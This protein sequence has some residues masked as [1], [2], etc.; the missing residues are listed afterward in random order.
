MDFFMTAVDERVKP[1]STLR[2]VRTLKAL[3]PPI[4]D[5]QTY[6]RLQRQ[7][8]EKNDCFYNSLVSSSL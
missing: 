6:N 3:Q 4:G 1:D 5:R 7:N 2:K 8:S